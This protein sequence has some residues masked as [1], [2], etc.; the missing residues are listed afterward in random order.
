MRIL[1]V[2]APNPGIRELEG[3]NTW[4]VGDG[5]TVV[6]DPGPDDPGHVR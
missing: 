6:I 5:P 4:I 1:R 2:L 3:T